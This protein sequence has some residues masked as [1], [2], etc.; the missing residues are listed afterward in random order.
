MKPKVFYENTG[1]NSLGEYFTSWHK[2][3]RY[4][5]K[6][7][8]CEI[9]FLIRGLVLQKRRNY[10]SYEFTQLTIRYDICTYKNKIRGTMMLYV[11]SIV[12][13][14]YRSRKVQTRDFTN[15]TVYFMNETL[16]SA[17]CMRTYTYRFSFI[18]LGSTS[19]LW[20]LT[21]FAQCFRDPSFHS[22]RI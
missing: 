13:L 14:F 4:A 11:T 16:I 12:F 8:N 1:G 15:D 20:F 6:N 18:C 17:T 7:K 10:I 22:F 19:I 9:K 2:I 3:I 5:R 21:S